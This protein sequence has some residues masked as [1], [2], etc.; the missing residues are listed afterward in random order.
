[1]ATGGISGEEGVGGESAGSSGEGGRTDDAVPPWVDRCGSRPRISLNALPSCELGDETVLDDLAVTTN[2]I[3]VDAERVYYV[4]NPPPG[5]PCPD[6]GTD[7]AAVLSVPKAGGSVRVHGAAFVTQQ[8]AVD[9]DHVYWV[10][11]ELAH[12]TKSGQS[13]GRT[14]VNGGGVIATGDA[15]YTVTSQP[16]TLSRLP[17]PLTSSPVGEVLA[18]LPGLF[19][20][21]RI[22]VTDGEWAYVTQLQSGPELPVYAVR[23]RDG[24]RRVLT[25]VN[26]ARGIALAG[27]HLLLSEESSRSVLKLDLADDSLTP[28]CVESYPNALA[29]DETHLYLNVQRLDADSRY[30]GQLVRLAIDGSQACVVAPDLEYS[31]APALDLENVYWVSHRLLRK[32]RK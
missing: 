8:I 16:W 22:L 15:I 1:M 19:S 3:A 11:G 17:T 29:A 6:D 27:N 4:G 23:L 10:A 7:C 26:V 30:H 31:S 20:A 5:V 12:S 14:F 32:L 24:R 2:A 18:E 13:G 9:D 28:L 21:P 25:S